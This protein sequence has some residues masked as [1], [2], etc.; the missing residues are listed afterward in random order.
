MTAQKYIF[1]NRFYKAELCYS[2]NVDGIYH[3]YNIYTRIY[4]TKDLDFL[5]NYIKITKNLIY[6]LPT[7]DDYMATELDFFMENIIFYQKYI[8][9]KDNDE[10]DI[11]YKIIYK[12]LEMINN[13]DYKIYKFKN[14]ES[15]MKKYEKKFLFELDDC[16]ESGY[17][18]HR[19]I[20]YM[21]L[22][23]L[24]ID[25]IRKPLQMGWIKLVAKMGCAP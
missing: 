14:L 4:E 18:E 2:D 15:F 21:N 12:V 7:F 5:I 1:K 8:Y 3:L 6:D 17:Y 10:P 22:A 19:D 16:K 11:D 23:L 13:L 20:K 25:E 9:P 24:K